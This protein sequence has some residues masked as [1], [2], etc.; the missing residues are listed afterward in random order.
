MSSKKSNEKNKNKDESSE[1]IR[2]KRL[3]EISNLLLREDMDFYDYVKTKRNVRRIFHK[4]IICKMRLMALQ[5]SYLSTSHSDD[6]GIKS[7][8]ISDPVGILLEKKEKYQKYIDEVDQKYKENKYMLN[9]TEILL[10]KLELID[11]MS[12]EKIC[13]ILNI[14]SHK[15]LM[16]YKKKL[17]IKVANWYNVEEMVDLE[18]WE[19]ACK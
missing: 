8:Q 7:N 1:L 3:Q 12:D 6:L 18:P 4:Y 19:L 10:Y 11:C 13:E 2:H 16:N 14:N 15:T 5:S 9:D 17:Y